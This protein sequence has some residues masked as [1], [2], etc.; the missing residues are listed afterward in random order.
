[1]DEIR[2]MERLEGVKVSKICQAVID[3]ACDFSLEYCF[4]ND[5]QHTSSNIG[6]AASL[7]DSSRGLLIEDLVQ[8]PSQFGDMRYLLNQVIKSRGLKPIGMNPYNPKIKSIEFRPYATADE[9]VKKVE[10]N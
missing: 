3:V 7:R 4:R 1:M 10:Q 8:H 9:L 5:V 6:I 2:L